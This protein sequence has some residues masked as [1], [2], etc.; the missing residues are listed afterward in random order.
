MLDADTLEKVRRIR[1][2]T[3]TILQSGIVGAYH[4][5]FKGR[6]MEFAQV[7][8]YAL[9]DDVRSVDWNVTA[10]MGTPY[11]KQ[12]VEERD[13]TLLLL[14]DL[15]GSQRFGSRF[16]VKRDYAAELAA[17]MAFSAVANHDRVGAVLFSDGI[18]SYVAPGRG[19]EHAMRIVR[20]LLALAP[21]GRGT[22][23]AGALRF[24]H[25][26][27]KRRGIVVIVSDF[28]DQ[29]YE[30]PLGILRRRHDVV[31]M[32]LWDPREQE[33]PAAGLVTL[34]DPETGELAC[35]DT[36][37]PEVRRRLR[38]ATLA[39]ARQVFNRTRVDALSLSTAED[40]ARPL[41][42]FFEARE[43]RR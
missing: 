9:G 25:R 13:L 31:A 18:E 12:Y 7:R 16:L 22:D 15:S 10:R 21:R 39:E 6:G 19:Q 35:V 34:R 4:A 41:A 2:R 8:E 30:T 3:R 38:A 37:D 14:V 43:K 29:G 17:V 40:Y 1:I 28:Q 42:R 23:L 27:L 32:H 20:D 24:T 5:V 33:L 36:S 26:V 11:V